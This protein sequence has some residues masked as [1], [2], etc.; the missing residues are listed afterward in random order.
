[1]KCWV[2]EAYDYCGHCDTITVEP[3]TGTDRDLRLYLH[4]QGNR[5]L[6]DI[7]DELYYRIEA[8]AREHDAAM[9]AVRRHLGMT[10]YEDEA[11][12][13]AELGLPL[14]NE[15]VARDDA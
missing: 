3:F 6:H 12:E 1:M 5:P 4:Q 15:A 13:W 7:P 2:S 9:N 8:A 11:L 14:F 10:V